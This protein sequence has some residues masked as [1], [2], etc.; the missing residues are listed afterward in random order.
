MTKGEREGRD[1]MWEGQ[2]RR[3]RREVAGKSGE[4]IASKSK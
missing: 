3:E 4:H 1:W 2:C